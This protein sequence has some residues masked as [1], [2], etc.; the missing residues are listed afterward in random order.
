MKND[1]LNKSFLYMKT[2]LYTLCTA[3]LLL[4]ACTNDPAENILSNVPGNG[5]LP[6]GTFVID[7]TASTGDTRTRLAASERIQSLDY[8]L[9]EK[10]AGSNDFILKHRRPI[11]DIGKN[12]IWPLTRETM[13]WA[14][15]E[16]LK[17]TLNQS[18]DYKMVFVANADKSIWGDKEVLQ[19]VNTSNKFEDGRLVLPPRVFTENDMYYMWSNHDTPLRGSEYNKDNPAQMDI[20]LQRMINKVEV[21]LDDEVVNGINAAT[22]NS[23]AEKV[24]A[25]VTDILDEHYN[26][27][28]VKND[29]SGQLDKI[30]WAYMDQIAEKITYNDGIGSNKEDHSKKAFETKF[31]NPDEKRKAVVESIN[32]CEDGCTPDNYCVKHQFIAEMEEYFTKCCDWSSITNLTLSYTTSSYASAIAFNK[33]TEAKADATTI[34]VERDTEGNYIF[35]TFGNKENSNIN[36]ISSI[37]FKTSDNQEIFNA[38]CNTI[39]GNGT[40]SGN[41]HFLLTY[42]PTSQANIESDSELY[43]QFTRKEYNIQNVLNWSWDDSD[44]EYSSDIINIGWKRFKMIGWVNSLFFGNSPDDSNYQDEFE[45]YTLTLDIPKIKIIHPWTTSSVE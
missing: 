10:A 17:D 40:V 19:N 21:K 30:V 38:E 36:T 33:D 28:Y 25:Y 44:F 42:S 29:N 5:D 31:I 20:L 27:F 4:A 15:R 23:Y 43:F 11:P 12:T 16:A 37:S 34:N 8:L 3:A 32:K 18:S 9:Y 26:T 1:E 13:T 6:Q 35:Y 2:T 14:Q 24:D 22:G 7:Y 45:P 41:N 39:P